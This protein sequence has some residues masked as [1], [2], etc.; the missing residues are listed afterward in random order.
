MVAADHPCK[1]WT[2][3][4]NLNL[5][6]SILL[7]DTLVGLVLI[8]PVLLKIKTKVKKKFTRESDICCF[9]L[10]SSLEVKAVLCYYDYLRPYN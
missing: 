2:M 6:I 8:P 4:S 1:H 9:V 10:F 7:R 5:G 3:V